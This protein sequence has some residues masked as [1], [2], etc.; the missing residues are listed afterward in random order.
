[1]LTIEGLDGLNIFQKKLSD[2]SNKTRN[3]DGVHKI[4]VKELLN[5]AFLSKYTRFSSVDALFEN[6]G[7]KIDDAEAFKAI[8]DDEWDAYIRSISR[9]SDWK[10][11]MTAAGGD[12]I[13]KKLGL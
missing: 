7:F 6:S 5:S 12:W 1:M 9:F 2:L 8:P 13:K 11:M 10:D 3:L 4:P